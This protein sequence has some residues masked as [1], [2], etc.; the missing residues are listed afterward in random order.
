M[1][2]AVAKVLARFV[3]KSDDLS[4][5]KASQFLLKGASVHCQSIVCTDVIMDANE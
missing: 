1:N 3:F 2:S 4:G 5:A